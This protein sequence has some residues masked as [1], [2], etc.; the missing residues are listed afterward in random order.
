MDEFYCCDGSFFLFLFISLFFFLSFLINL[1]LFQAFQSNI[2]VFGFP[3]YSVVLM[4]FRTIVRASF[5]IDFCQVLV[6]PWIVVG[7]NRAATSTP[8]KTADQPLVWCQI[9]L[10]YAICSFTEI[11]RYISWLSSAYASSH[12]R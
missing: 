8:F 10:L 7:R 1:T 2:S 6:C 5:G 12:S 9:M 11:K 4:L 3:L